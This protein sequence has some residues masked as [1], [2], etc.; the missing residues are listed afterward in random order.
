MPIGTITGSTTKIYNI[1]FYCKIVL[2]TSKTTWTFLKFHLA[3]KY[4]K[5]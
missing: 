5:R 2:A 4:H 3:Q 1:N